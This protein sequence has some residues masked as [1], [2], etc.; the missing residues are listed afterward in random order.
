MRSLVLAAAIS[1]QPVILQAAPVS[2]LSMDVTGSVT[3]LDF[4]PHAFIGPDDT[5]TNIYSDSLPLSY[6]GLSG[7]LFSVDIGG[8][9]SGRI[10]LFEDSET[11][12]L[13]LDCAFAQYGFNLCGGRHSTRIRIWTAIWCC[14]QGV[15]DN[16]PA[17]PVTV[18][19]PAWFTKM[20][21][22]TTV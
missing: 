21:R 18:T 1:F 17:S 11:S 14:F 16:L 22:F 8:S 7:G 12:F 6:Y 5:Y 2:I 15:A 9:V 20:P 13:S 4:R 19:R 10:T 3:S